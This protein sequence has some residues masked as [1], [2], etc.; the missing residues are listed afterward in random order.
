M[1]KLILA[2][3]VLSL[4][5]PSFASLK[6]KDVIG[7]WKYK[8]E[9]D[10]GELT[11]KIIIEKKE[12]NLIA[13]VQT[14]EGDVLPFEK[15]ELRENDVLYMEIYNGYETLEVTVTVKDK[16]FKGTVGSEQGS[17]PITAEKIE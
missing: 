5:L 11:G 4:A 17:L 1:K 3:L 10:Q 6:D 7:T 8:V 15:V 2:F 16:V 14:D 13:E 12:G 9:T